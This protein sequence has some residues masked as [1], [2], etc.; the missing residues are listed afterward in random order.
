MWILVSWVTLVAGLVAGTQC[1]DGQFCPIACCLDPGG[2][3]YSCCSPVPEKWS[4]TLSRPLSSTCQTHA[5]CPAGYSCIITISG[6]SS[7]CPFPKAVSCGDGSHCCPWGFHCSAD[8]QS[9]FRRPDNNLLGAVQCPG[10]QFECP[11]SSTCCIMLDGSWGCCP[12]PQA[13]CC[14]DR[15]HCCPHGASCDLVHIRCITPTGTHPL[16]KKIPA[17]RTKG[18]AALPNSILCPDAQSRCPDDSTCC[19]LPSGKYGCCPMPNAICCSDHLHCCPQDTV[20]DLIQSKCLSKE[21]A[22]DLLTKMPAHTVQEVK[23]DMEVSCPDG[24]TC[25]RLQS[26]A[27][28]CCPFTQAVC[29]EDHIHCCPAGFKCYTEKGTCEQG[30]LQVPW[31]EKVPAHFSLPDPPSLKIDVPCDNFTSCPSSNT[32]CRLSSGEWGCCPIPEVHGLGDRKAVCCLDHLHCCPEGYTCTAEGQCQWGNKIIAGLEKVPTRQASLS[33]SR[34]IGCDQHTSCPV[35]QT[36]CPSLSGGWACCQ[37]PHAVCCEDRQ[38]CCPAGYTCNVKART[39]EKEVD[40][41][42]PAARLALGST[43]DVRDVAC[44]GGRFCHDNQTCCPYKRGSWACCP[45]RQGV[46]CADRRHCC[47]AGFHC[48]AKGTKCL[49]RNTQRWDTPRWD[50]PLRGPSPRQLL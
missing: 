18:E 12:M 24:Y 4:T 28:G 38:H 36:C 21:N 30:T 5:H 33:H 16:A 41:S 47:P 43:V 25:C 31:M 29:C 13:S 22:T 48:G 9:C 42:Y 14:E 6:T 45:Y 2:A 27:W 40:S 3:S 7:C 50:T 20:C 37:L 44:G 1:P 19:E 11:D 35:G 10:S 46:C 23:C 34:D 39:C 49:R 15:V 17:K 26:G 32:C 8:G